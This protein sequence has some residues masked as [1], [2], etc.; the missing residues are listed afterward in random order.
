MS[1]VE[2]RKR[3]KRK[4]KAAVVGNDLTTVAT[5][6]SAAAAVVTHLDHLENKKLDKA[7][8]TIRHFHSGSEYFRITIYKKIKVLL[9]NASSFSCCFFSSFEV[10]IERY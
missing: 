1:L 7:A 8:C 4:R 3:M 5:R 10:D 9:S 6:D 2:Y